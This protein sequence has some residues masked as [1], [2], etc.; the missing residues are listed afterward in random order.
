MCFVEE[1]LYAC[2]HRETAQNDCSERD[3][4]REEC[5]ADQL[6]GYHSLKNCDRCKTRE[7]LL[8]EDADARD[9]QIL[10]LA[11]LLLEEREKV[12]EREA[13]KATRKAAKK[14]RRTE[15]KVREIERQSQGKKKW[16]WSFS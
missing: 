8:E 15:R 7:E 9:Q 4:L 16:W 11:A 3:K 13:Q 2:G 1:I 6:I 5:R 10:V 12:Q 14:A